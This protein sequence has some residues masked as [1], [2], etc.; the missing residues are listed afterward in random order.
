M[1][2]LSLD[3]K[4]V[5]TSLHHIYLIAIGTDKDYAYDSS[6]E[7]LKDLSMICFAPLALA[8]IGPLLTSRGILGV[9][10]RMLT[11]AVN[12]NSENIGMSVAL[13][14]IIIGLSLTLMTIF[15]PIIRMIHIVERSLHEKITEPDGFKNRIKSSY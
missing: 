14:T 3:V 1:M 9:L 6:A 12:N 8:I 4:L 13:C 10:A 15:S 2:T 5:M 11:I 7:I